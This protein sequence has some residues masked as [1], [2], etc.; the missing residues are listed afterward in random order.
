MKTTMTC[1]AAAVIAWATSGVASG[2]Y[3]G[4]SCDNTEAPAEARA[5]IACTYECNT[6]TPP[7]TDA[8]TG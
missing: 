7:E 2:C 1:M 8:K 5:V 6:D 4:S 3:N